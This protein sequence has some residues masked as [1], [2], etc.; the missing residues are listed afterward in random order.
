MKNSQA[1][2]RM[3]VILLMIHTGQIYP[4]NKSSF[5]YQMPER[6]SKL[7]NHPIPSQ[8]DA[9]KSQWNVFTD[10]LFLKADE[11]A[12][13]AL[14][15]DFM[16]FTTSGG[17]SAVN[18][19]DDARAVQF[20]W[21]LGIRAGFGYRFEENQWDTQI[22]YT[23]FHTHGKDHSV[24]SNSN[25]NITTAFL[26][27]WLTFGFSS[28]SGHIQWK[29]LLNAIDWE[30]GRQ[31]DAGKGLSFRPHLGIKGGWIDQTIHSQWTSGQFTAT[32]NLKNNFWGLGPKGGVNSNWNIGSIHNHLFNLF[33][34]LSLALLG[35]TWTFKDIQKTSM[36][37]SLSGVNP[38]T[39]AATFM[40]HGLMGFSWDVKFGKNQSNFGIRVGYE[41][42]YWYDQ[43]KIFTFLEGTLH[44]ALVLQG[45]MLDVHFNY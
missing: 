5:T 42:Q 39:R 9:S 41:F 23:W 43:L 31:S 7:E 22:Y 33:G 26:G 30:I 36:D 14:K 3:L 21:D 4:E 44:A 28:S 24:A 20:D 16:P 18:Y 13:W 15:V 37:S 32:E 40:F 34:D 38:K 12:T 8:N 11:I 29:I 6:D 19:S 25:S 17:Q 45:G 2:V 35:G 10:L 27:E 1:L